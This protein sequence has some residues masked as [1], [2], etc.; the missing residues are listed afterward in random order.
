MVETGIL[1]EKVESV[2]LDPDER[3]GN[4]DALLEFETSQNGRFIL[5]EIQDYAPKVQARRDHS[6]LESFQIVSA[7][8]DAKAIAA[9]RDPYA[10]MRLQLC[11]RDLLAILLV[12]LNRSC[13]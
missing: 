2:S 7:G 4:A 11:K 8:Y 6:L 12:H 10:L 13:T 9:E 5:Q 1:E 3:A